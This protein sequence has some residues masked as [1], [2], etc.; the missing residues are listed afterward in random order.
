VL[1]GLLVAFY[2]RAG[3]LP[4]VALRA[5]GTALLAFILA[6]LALRATL[7]KGGSYAA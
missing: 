3:W 7:S 2:L 5:A 1:L 4:A 6:L